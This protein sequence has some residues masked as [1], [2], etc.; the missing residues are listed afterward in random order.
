[1]Q[2]FEEI[3]WVENFTQTATLGNDGV[4]DFNR[5]TELSTKTEQ[6]VFTL[7]LRFHSWLRNQLI[8][9]FIKLNSIE[10]K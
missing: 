5:K 3:F 6:N 7:L 1:M 2:N 8:K 10:T 4:T 9:Q